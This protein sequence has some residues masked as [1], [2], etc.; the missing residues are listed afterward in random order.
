MM[1]EQTGALPGDE[2]AVGQ[3]AVS[4]GTLAAAL[5]A[6]IRTPLSQVGLAASQL[7]REALTPSSR[8]LAERILGAVSDIDGLV[9][10]MLRVLV[11]RAGS[12]RLEDLRPLLA[13]LH[14]RF[15]PVLAACGVRWERSSGSEVE[16]DPEQVRRL[17]IALL[18]LAL[19]ACGTGGGFSLEF[20]AADEGV[21]LQ[22]HCQRAGDWNTDD[23]SVAERARE[24][25]RGLAIE[26]GGWLKCSRGLRS[27][28]LR[29]WVP[30]VNP[31]EAGTL[32]VEATSMDRGEAWDAS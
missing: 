8:A 27:A 15:V 19:P 25:A 9:E 26:L 5:S 10:R 13:T 12:H 28:E 21:E 14:Q 30:E 31:I 4:R 6:E 22:L 23:E 20:F 29:L 2:G 1:R 7:T 11:P 32:V 16:G 17:V 3:V 24:E 18:N